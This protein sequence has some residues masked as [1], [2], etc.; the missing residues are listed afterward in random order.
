[1]HSPWQKFRDNI[2]VI[3]IQIDEMYFE[4]LHSFQVII[5]FSWFYVP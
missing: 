1:M 2:D 3:F 5:D 4:Y